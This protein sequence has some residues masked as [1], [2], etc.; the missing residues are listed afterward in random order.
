MLED[1]RVRA[2]A[3]RAYSAWRDLHGVAGVPTEERKAKAEYHEAMEMLK[4]ILNE[5]EP[6]S[7][8]HPSG[9]CECGAPFAWRSCKGL[10]WSLRVGTA[11]VECEIPEDIYAWRCVGCDNHM[12]DRKKVM[13]IEDAVRAWHEER[14]A[15]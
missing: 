4:V 11:I 13:E 12:M 5:S 7:K 1:E 3:K 10:P 14:G 8:W 15:L 6:P 9:R 2:A